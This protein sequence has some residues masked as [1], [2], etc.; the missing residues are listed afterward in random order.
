MQRYRAYLMENGHVWT[1]LELSCT[2]DDDAK[3][4]TERLLNGRDIE[5]WQSDRRIAFFRS[6]A[7]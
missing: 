4:Q 2:D 6:Q 3:R 1:V 5:L 7:G